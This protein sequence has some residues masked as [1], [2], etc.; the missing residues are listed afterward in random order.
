MGREARL[1]R[2][3]P[4]CRRNLGGAD[5][6]RAEGGE[7]PV[8]QEGPQPADAEVCTESTAA[9]GSAQRPGRGA[10]EGGPTKGKYPGAYCRAEHV[11]GVVRTEGPT[12]VD[13]AEEWKHLRRSAWRR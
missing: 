6:T 8:A 1:T 10:E 13:T 11:R 2:R 12:E 4:T 5:G 3:R 7:V 9:E